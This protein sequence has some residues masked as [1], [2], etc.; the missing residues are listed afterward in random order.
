MTSVRPL[1]GRAGLFRQIVG[2]QKG[3]ALYPQVESFSTPIKRASYGVVRL[4]FVDGTG[5]ASISRGDREEEGLRTCSII[6]SPRKKWGKKCPSQS[7]SGT[8]IRTSRSGG[9]DN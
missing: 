7:I 9:K 8:S 4:P 5:L 3:E 1:K 2:S 6:S